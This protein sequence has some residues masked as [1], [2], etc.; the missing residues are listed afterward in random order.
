M[1]GVPDM[2][3]YN[4]FNTIQPVHSVYQL[5]NN[6]KN[7]KRITYFCEACGCVHEDILLT[8]TVFIKGKSYCRFGVKKLLNINKDNI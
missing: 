3:I 8:D 1:K 6:S 2:T 5:N 7:K 4:N